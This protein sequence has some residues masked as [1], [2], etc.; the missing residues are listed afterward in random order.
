MD[1][2]IRMRELLQQ[3]KEA[4]DAY[5]LEDDPK[6][7]D[8]QYD[9]LFDELAA[10]EQETGIVYANSPT[11]KVQGGVL[12]ELESVTHTKPML[13]AEK[14]KDTRKI[15]AFAEDGVKEAQNKFVV[16]SWK[17]DGL[18]LVLRYRNGKLVQVITRGDGDTGEDVTHNIG[19]VSGVPQQLPASAPDYV[20]VRGE[21]VVS[22]KEFEEV[23]EEAEEAYAHP[24]GLAAGSI[25]LLD[26]AESRK[27][28]LQFVAFELVEPKPVLVSQGYDSMAQWGFQ[29]VPHSIVPVAE[30]EAAMEMYDPKNYPLPVDG[31][32][33]EYNDKAYGDSLGATGH[34]E[35]CRM[36]FKWQDETYKTKFRGVVLRPT[37]TGRVSLT[38]S[39]DPVVIDGSTVTKATLH[40]FDI[41][42][43]LELG[44]GDELEV[45]KANRIIP[46]IDKN[47]TRSGSYELPQICPCCGS[48][49]EVQKLK[50]TRFLMCPNSDCSAK[51]VRKYEHFCGRGYMNIKGLS[52]STL[53]KLVENGFISCYRDIYHL[54]E[55]QAK[56][57]TLEGFGA[58]A[59]EK[60][61]VAVEK[62]KDVTLTSF[63][64]SFGITMVGRHAAK[65]LE[66][67]FGT[68]EKLL[69]AVDSGYDFSAV[70]DFGSQRSQYLMEFFRD[71]KHRT[72]VLAVAAEVRLQQKT[73]VPVGDGPFAGKTVVATGSF[74][75][76]SRDGIN[77]YLESLGAKAS[78][79]VSKKTDYVIV[80]PG[81]GS[82][83]AKA[84]TLGIPVLSEDEFLA[85]AKA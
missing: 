15:V 31:L 62:S 54:G 41:F 8:K 75:N 56:I 65:N 72:E 51:H 55:S 70:K 79:S 34:H 11:Q 17:L 58:R 44:I 73:A 43:E 22:R 10:L 7:S 3:M 9:A 68:L 30:I 47:S 59:V 81:A 50:G 37:R 83:L 40:N 24:R 84:Q 38:A 66:K 1:K 78:G 49:L 67:Q 42:T 57:A 48:R 82:K 20:E 6:M 35:R 69:E 52:G 77:E 39:F 61:L 63:L 29:V 5:Y 32:I 4:S 21:C 16:I 23:N 13:S 64:A 80:G 27:R 46:A 71:E 14:T 36:A 33:A 74:Q 28:K 19:G 76:F 60:L 45:Y 26:P 53:R 85:M 2:L 18:T 25:R 12:P